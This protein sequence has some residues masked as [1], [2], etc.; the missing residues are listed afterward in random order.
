MRSGHIYHTE[1]RIGD[2]VTLQFTTRIKDYTV[3]VKVDSNDQNFSKN[4]QR[5]VEAMQFYCPEADGTLTTPK[6]IP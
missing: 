6:A 1:K 5:L 2:Q 4:A 3:R